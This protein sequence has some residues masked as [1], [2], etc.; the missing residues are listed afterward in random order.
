MSNFVMLPEHIINNI[1]E[2]NPEHR[3]LF[4]K[5]LKQIFDKCCC[6]SCDSPCELDFCV[7]S[8]RRIFCSNSCFTF[9]VNMRNDDNEFL[10]G[11][12]NEFVNGEDDFEISEQDDVD[13]YDDNEQFI[14]DYFD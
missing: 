8:N 3:E 6:I 4:Q 1:H 7:T 11:D 12:D 10:N 2:Y 13:E 5:T 14:Y 9:W